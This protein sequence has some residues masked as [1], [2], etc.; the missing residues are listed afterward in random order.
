MSKDYP[1]PVEDGELRE[2]LAAIEHERWA[3]W[4]KW[5]HKVLREN[6]PSPEQGD[7]L[8][9][10]D[11]QIETPYAELSEKEKQ[12]D[13]DQ[14]DRYWQLVEAY[15]A[16]EK[17]KWVAEVESAVI[18]EENSIVQM[19]AECEYCGDITWSN[20]GIECPYCGDTETDDLFYGDGH[21]DENHQCPTCGKN[22]SVTASCSW[23]WEAEP[24]EEVL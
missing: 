16:Q 3:D 4:Q 9:R 10:W 23:H 21:K 2:Q 12:S 15:L 19:G 17:A 22:F 13:R 8:E 6:N 20:D 14:V 1:K 24:T 18:G 11:R 7:I 5:C